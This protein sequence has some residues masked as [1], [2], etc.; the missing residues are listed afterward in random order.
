MKFNSK[1]IQAAAV[2]AVALATGQQVKAPHPLAAE[3]GLRD[4]AFACGDL[5]R[6]C[7]PGTHD[8]A[9]VG[10]GMGTADFSALLAKG[11]S[12]ATINSY[13]AQ[14]EH[15]KFC[16]R[17]EVID[18]QPSELPALDADLGLEPLLEGA[19]ITQGLAF[20]S[21]G[22]T[23]VQ[24]ITYAKAIGVSRELIINNRTFALGHIFAGL[25]ASAARTEARLVAACLEANQTLDDGNVVFDAAYGNVL[26]QALST[27]NLGAAMALLRNQLT[28]AGQRADYRARHLVVA[29][30]LEFVAHTLV[31]DSGIDLTVST[32][33]DL[34]DGRWYLTADPAICPTIATLVLQSAKVPVRVEAKRRPINLDGAAVQVVAD[35]GATLLRR[36]GIIRGGV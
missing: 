30:D 17:L 27:L 8:L 23:A 20:L 21:A 7:S 14:A 31:V 11:A 13:A 25:G 35:L 33:A 24:L 22:S 18:F 26:P 5:A 36:V 1:E 3:I 34:P 6:K 10:Y 9:I 28:S 16:S 2:D 4:I 19:K 32:L 29:S 15:S 12:A